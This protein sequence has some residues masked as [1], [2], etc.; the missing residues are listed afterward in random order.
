MGKKAIAGILFFVL[1]AA[2]AAGMF[3]LD[4]QKEQEQ[5]DVLCGVWEMEVAVPREDV[6]TLLENNDFYDEEITLADLGALSYV[7]TVTFREDGTYRFSVDT[8][9]SQARVEEFFR[10]V[11]QKLFA[12]RE[13]LNEIYDVDFG[14]MDEAQFQ[15]F[16]AEIYEMQDFE[17]LIS[18]FSQ[19]ALNLEAMAE[20]ESGD[21]KLKNGKIDFVTSSIDQPGA[22]DYAIDG[23]KL[24]IT[25]VD[26][27]EEYTRAK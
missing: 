9:A 26:G 27:V 12:G 17:A 13:T 21:F 10:G 1:A 16:Y 14:Q 4:K 22:A 20:L 8:E 2:V 15:Q 25:Y 24:T 7:Q 23:E 11:F 18:L 3:F 5:M 19:N 6:R